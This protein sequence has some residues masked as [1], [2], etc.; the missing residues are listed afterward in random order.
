MRT[1]PTDMIELTRL[2]GDALWWA[3]DAF[4]DHCGQLLLDETDAPDR[5]HLAAA[6][7][8]GNAL[9][10]SLKSAGVDRTIER[11]PSSDTCAVR[12]ILK[13]TICMDDAFLALPF[14]EQDWESHEQWEQ[15]CDQTHRTSTV[16][17][18]LLKQL[19]DERNVN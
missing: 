3:C 19:N 11:F 16:L 7:W 8:A 5:T 9:R 14:R 12:M 1:L 2:E 17:R 10:E 13:T 15:A 6:T 4:F 18:G